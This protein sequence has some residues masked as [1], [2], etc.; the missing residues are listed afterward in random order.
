[1]LSVKYKVGA[2][3]TNEGEHCKENQREFV[4]IF[5]LQS[6]IDRISFCISPLLYE[7]NL[8][9]MRHSIHEFAEYINFGSSFTQNGRNEG[10]N[11]EIISE[12]IYYQSYDRDTKQGLFF[13]FYKTCLEN[14]GV[15]CS[16]AFINILGKNL[17][18]FKRE[19]EK[20]LSLQYY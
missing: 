10:N 18:N 12:M 5:T 8:F 1:M 17:R 20:D 6:Q 9:F 2:F 11:L 13:F 16:L 4:Q 14:K 19:T 15:P 3:L 7:T